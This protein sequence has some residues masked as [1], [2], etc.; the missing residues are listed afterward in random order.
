MDVAPDTIVVWS[1]IACPWGTVA[2]HRL[3]AAID[4]R[5]LRRRL[6]IDHRAF[7]LELV[8][9]RPTPKPIL[10]AEIP[11]AGALVPDAGWQVWQA[12]E[13]EWPV[14][15]VPAMEA[16]QAAKGQGLGASAA[17]DLALREALFSDSRC[18]AI[19][20]VILDVACTCPEVDVTA[21]GAALDAGEG[22]ASLIEQCQ[23]AMTDEVTGSPHVFM[24]DGTDLHNPGV[25]I[26]WQG[27]HGVGFPVVDRDDPS[28]YDDLLDR[29]VRAAA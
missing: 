18:I 9:G 16:V 21:L 20:P 29:A 5:G 12:P 2:V 26:H 24:A 15:T 7:P 8:N 19:R 1:D 11:V 10:D 6:A 22:R 4:R 13:S 23:R 14:T 17:L 3:H 28:I 27:E 25:T